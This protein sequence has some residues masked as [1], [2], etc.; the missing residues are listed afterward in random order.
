MFNHQETSQKEFNVEE[1]HI[2]KAEKENKLVFQQNGICIPLENKKTDV[3]R[4]TNQAP[5]SHSPLSVTIISR[6]LKGIPQNPHFYHL[7]GYTDLTRKQLIAGWDRIF[8]E[9]V[10]QIHSLKPANFQ[11]KV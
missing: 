6:T 1:P 7:R 4:E 11:V 8:E 9:T 2:E 5:A 3:T 10:D